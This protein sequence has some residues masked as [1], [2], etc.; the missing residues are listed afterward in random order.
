M[1]SSTVAKGVDFLSIFSCRTYSDA[2]FASTDVDARED[3]H[4]G[5]RLLCHIYLHELN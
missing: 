4:F 5:C 3:L 1:S 2:Q